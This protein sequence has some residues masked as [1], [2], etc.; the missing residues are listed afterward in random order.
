MSAA[1]AV[2]QSRPTGTHRRRVLVTLARLEARRYA[3]HPLFVLGVLANVYLCIVQGPDPHTSVMTLTVAPAATIGVLGMF[4]TFSLTRRSD[5]L[6]AAAG[7][8]PVAERTRTLALITACV[9]PFAA[10]LA[11]WLWG[12]LTYRHHPPPPNGY[13]FGPVSHGWVA[14]VL[15]GEVPIASLG[16]PL[17]GIAMARWIDWIAAPPLVAVTLIPACIFTDGVVESLRRIRVVMPWTLF[18]GPVGIRGDAMRTM[19]LTGSPQW[20][21]LYIACL[22]A[23]AAIAAL[24]H[25]RD[26]R[27]RLPFAAA[28]VVVIA[29][30]SVLLA[31]YGG[32]DHTLINPLRSS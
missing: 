16:G 24:W 14:V 17:L 1:T 31:M 23:L 8:V 7:S 27:G 13:P 26:Q 12:Y 10:G 21:L 22:C 6:A 30:A 11:W 5:T 3:L 20:W 28:T 32:L 9:V 2:A 4:V 29:I 25:D 18:G 15:F 19:I